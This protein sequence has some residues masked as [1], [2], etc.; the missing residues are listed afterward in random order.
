MYNFHKNTHK[1]GSNTTER[2]FGSS[3]TGWAAE[4]TTLQFKLTQKTMDHILG[5]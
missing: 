2:F 4:Y 5:E 3:K 1:H